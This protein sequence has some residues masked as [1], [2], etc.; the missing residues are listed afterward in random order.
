M[1]VQIPSHS[2]CR[3]GL[4]PCAGPP[5]TVTVSDPHRFYYLQNFQ[6]ALA[7]LA[8]RYADILRPEEAEFM[9]QFSELPEP[10]RALFVRMTMRRGP[11]FRTG[12][13]GYD[14]I[15]CPHAAALPLIACGWIDA[16]PQLS[17]EEVFALLTRQELLQT[18]ITLRSSP[19]TSVQS[20]QQPRVQ[21]SLESPQ[22]PSVETSLQSRQQQPVQTPLHSPQLTPPCAATL[23]LARLR[24]ADLLQTLEDM[25]LAA[26]SYRAWS[27]TASDGVFSLR[28]TSLCERLRAMFFG[29]LRQQWSEFVLADLGVFRYESVVI[30]R[31]SRPFSCAE[32]VDHFLTLHACRQALEAGHPSSEIVDQLDTLPSLTGWLELRAAKLRFLIGQCAERQQ[33]WPL[34]LTCYRSSTYPGARYRRLRVLERSGDASQALIDATTAAAAPESDEERQR[35]DRMLPRLRRQCGAA[36][37][38]VARRKTSAPVTLLALPRSDAGLSVERLVQAHLNRADAPAFYVENTLV[39]S[40]FGLLCWDAI[41]AA[42]PGAFFHPFQT[43]PADLLSPTFRTHRS[44]L[45]GQALSQ[46]D[47]TRWH[48]TVRDRYAAKHGIYSPFVAWSAL[49]PDLLELALRCIAPHHLRAWFERLLDNIKANRTGW[50]DLIQFFP[51]QASY[52]LVEV[53]GPGDRLQ[54]NQRRC[55][56]F[57]MH[58][59]VPVQVAYVEW[60]PE[61]H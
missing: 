40:L 1:T 37:V 2:A 21:T 54:D 15:G 56:D 17:V 20:P 42:V 47:S 48:D 38:N 31:L 36:P 59:G 13:L 44:E 35:L 23:P 34:A 58:H 53:K 6:V 29:N 30:D 7:W 27:P 60:A 9:R 16:D 45:L 61:P 4:P 3:R 51:D 12:K 18:A 32:D 43:G 57:C 5:L 49:S 46:L 55:L 24:K 39:N 22:Q 50:P 8:E 26:R 14:E 41:F 28:T 25:Q 33:A 19:P 52:A 10:S 11:L